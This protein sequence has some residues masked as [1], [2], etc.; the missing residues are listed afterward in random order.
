MYF[1]CQIMAE[2]ILVSQFQGFLVRSLSS[3][4]FFVTL[5]KEV[6][7]H[8]SHFPVIRRGMKTDLVA[9]LYMNELCS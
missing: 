4:N 1:S 6:Y 7:P 8:F 9:Y 2:E 3:I 5:G